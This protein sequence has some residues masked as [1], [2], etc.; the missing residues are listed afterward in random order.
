MSDMDFYSRLRFA[1]DEKGTSV[2]NMCRRLNISSGVIGNWKR[3]V[4]PTGGVLV[5]ISIFLDVSADWL[6]F[7]AERPKKEE[8]PDPNETE[9]LNLF[10][11][12]SERDKIKWIVRTEDYVAAVNNIT[13]P[14]WSAVEYDK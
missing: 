7:G 3:G 9:L 4:L 11:Q 8:R 13:A 14:W 1:C 12:L 5:K 10:R 2:T 6:L